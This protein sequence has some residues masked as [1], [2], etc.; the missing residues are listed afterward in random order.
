MKK[1][2]YALLGIMFL[3]GCEEA[4]VEGVTSNSQV[5][6]VT[7][8]S[9]SPDIGEVF[10]GSLSGKAYRMTSQNDWPDTMLIIAFGSNG[11]YTLE[12]VN[13]NPGKGWANGPNI[14]QYSGTWSV[15]KGNLKLGA[16]NQNGYIESK[17]RKISNSVLCWDLDEFGACGIVL[18]RV[19][20]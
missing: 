18:V 4:I 5:N 20:S 19:K 9:T 13:I 15:N 6:D 7:K 16:N 14:L 1:L 8:P 3:A 10:S 12:L 17:L 2:K 11:R